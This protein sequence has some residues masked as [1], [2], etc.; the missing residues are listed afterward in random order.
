MQPEPIGTIDRDRGVYS[1][2]I[3]L[4]LLKAVTERGRPF[5]FRAP[6]FS[7]HPF[8]RN[9]DIITIAP[10]P[11]GRPGPGDVVAFVRP[12]T[13]KLVVH[14]VVGRTDGGYLIRGDNNDEP[15]GLIPAESVLGIVVRVEHNGRDVSAGLGCERRLIALLSRPGLLRRTNAGI[16]LFKWLGAAG[17]QKA[18]GLAVYRRLAGMLR[19]RIAIT[20]ADER[21]MSDLYAGWLYN[22]A[23]P[24]YRPDPL[25]TNFVAKAGGEIVGFVQLVR[26]PEEHYPYTGYWLFSLMVRVPYRGM[27]LGRELSSRVIEMAEE[28]GAPEVS[29]LVNEKN[30]PA[31]ALYK[32]LRFEPVTIP[33]LAERLEAESA[34]TGVRRI[35]MRRVLG[36]DTE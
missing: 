31:V 27:G 24:P 22:P 28:E 16:G 32:Q 30:R 20:E 7:M 17:L 12:G 15:D 2:E 4:E 13:G 11:P 34:S 33:D 23:N 35:P 3:R 26:H 10:L 36:T 25:V 1:S 8:I 14:R 19:P 6:G 5:R 29:L 21:D 18:Q 9:G